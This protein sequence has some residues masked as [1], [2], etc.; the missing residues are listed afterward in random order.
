MRTGGEATFAYL[1]PD[2]GCNACCEARCLHSKSRGPCEFPLRDMWRH[3]KFRR[4][5]SK[6][7]RTDVV[8]TLTKHVRRRHLADELRRTG[9]RSCASFAVREH[10]RLT[11]LRFPRGRRRF[12]ADCVGSAHTKQQRWER[13]NSCCVRYRRSQM[14]G[15]QCGRAR[16]WHSRAPLMMQHSNIL[17]V[18]QLNPPKRCPQVSSYSIF[19]I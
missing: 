18:F 1:I 17:L 12:S 16:S 10:L 19:P 2:S 11:Q 6:V 4:V 15:K 9:G 8:S 5:L 13:R 14:S 7:R 3:V